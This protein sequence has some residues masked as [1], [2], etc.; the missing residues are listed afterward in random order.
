MNVFSKFAVFHCR[1]QIEVW[2]NLRLNRGAE[3]ASAGLS[4]S[5]L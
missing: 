2:G 5:F 3:R 4:V 1:R